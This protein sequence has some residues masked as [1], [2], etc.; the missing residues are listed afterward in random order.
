MRIEQ[1]D[2]VHWLEE[3][4]P[5]VLVLYDASSDVGYW[6]HIQQYFRDLPRLDVAI[7]GRRLTLLIPR[8][9]VLDRAAMK[10]LARAKNAAARDYR[11]R[12]T[13]AR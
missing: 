4:L 9:N 3:P 10:T 2:L 13:H 11:S 12:W 6:L 8:S 5:V 1:A 7:S